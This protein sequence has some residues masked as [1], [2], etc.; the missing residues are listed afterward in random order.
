MQLPLHKAYDFHCQHRNQHMDI[1]RNRK[2]PI[3][4]VSYLLFAPAGPATASC[5]TATL[6]M[7]RHQ[8]PVRRCVVPHCIIRQICVETM[9]HLTCTNM[10]VEKLEQALHDVRGRGSMA[11]A[12]Q[13]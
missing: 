6:R 7:P 10:P 4:F 5:K 1:A 11:G 9:M 3:V 8:A 2:T 12:G 13:C